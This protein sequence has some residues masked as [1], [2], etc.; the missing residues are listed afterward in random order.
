MRETIF[1][2]LAAL[3]LLSAGCKR[4]SVADIPLDKSNPLALAPDVK[5]ALVTDPYAAYRDKASWEAGASAYERKGAILQALAETTNADGVWYKFE[6][7]WLPA[8]ALSIHDNR[9][10]AET[11]AKNIKARQN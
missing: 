6:R 11:S 3:A 2:A 5:W 7:G 4:S 10:K 1:A 8:S 9:Y